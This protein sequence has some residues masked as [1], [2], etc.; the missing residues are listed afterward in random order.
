[1]FKPIKAFI[2]IVALIVGVGFL[3]A[4]IGQLI[5]SF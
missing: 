4:L 1:M 5:Q 2:K 3:L